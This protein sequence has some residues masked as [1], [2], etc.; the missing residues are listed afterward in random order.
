MITLTQRVS[1][2]QIIVKGLAVTYDPEAGSQTPKVDAPEITVNGTPN[3]TG[4]YPVNTTVTMTAG[5]EMIC[6]TLDGTVPTTDSELYTEPITLK[7]NKTYLIKAIAYDDDFNAS[8]VS[9]LE[10]KVGEAPAYVT[11]PTITVAGEQDGED[12]I[13]GATASISAPGASYVFYS[14]DGT[15]NFNE[16]EGESA[17]L[18]KLPAGRTT[19]KAYCWD[20]DANASEVV[21]STVN[22]VK[23]APEIAWSKTSCKVFLGEEPYELPELV[24]PHDLKVTYSIPDTDA[25][26]AT[27]DRETGVVTIVGVGT[28][29]VRATYTTTADSDYKGSWVSYTLTVTQRAEDDSE[30]AT[31]YT[32]DFTSKDYGRDTRYGLTLY[33]SGTNYE[34]DAENPVTSISDKGLTLTFS[35]P[36][37]DLDLQYRAWQGSVDKGNDLRVYNAIMTFSVGYGKIKSVTFIQT[38]SSKWDENVVPELNKVDRTYVWA[39]PEGKP[40]KSV[41]FKFTSRSDMGKIKVEY[42]LGVPAM[43]Y[44]VSESDDDV[45]VECDAICNLRYKKT[46]QN[47]PAG[48]PARIADQDEWYNHGSHTITI[49]KKEAENLGRDF[50]FHAYHDG[51]G[52]NS[53]ELILSVANDG[54]VTGIEEIAVDSDENAPVEYYDLQG[55]RIIN[56]A[57]GGIY[58]RRQ[59]N[60]VAKIRL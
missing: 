55:R 59:G 57:N 56:P 45:V 12:Y 30:F 38:A 43:P 49:S 40:L 19:I 36:D 22:V 13:I 5:V 39:A 6:Y 37:N 31:E 24:N 25:E 42:D 34:K 29:N 9:E 28:T 26:I 4:Y 8:E 18:G 47:T 10:V 1:G 21:T 46:Q 44:I 3:E 50:T 33:S 14:L 54:S 2:K 16:V 48:M 60:S 17:D 32:F 7:E 27:V 58:I 35:Q 53:D 11:P 23:K 41:S 20:A 15:D 51:T 52:V